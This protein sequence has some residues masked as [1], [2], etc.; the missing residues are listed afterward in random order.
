MSDGFTIDADPAAVVAALTSLGDAAQ[1]YINAAS[2]ETADA[3]VLEAK[4][5]LQRKLGP[6]A[7]GE[8][9]AGI[10]AVPARDGNGYLVLSS[11][12]RIGALPLWLELGTKKGHAGS[13]AS[14]ALAYFYSAQQLQEGSHLRRIQDALQ[15]AIAE[16][17]LGDA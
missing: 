10:E 12:D 11:N 9:V 2:K 3:L 8:T 16:R 15:R 7:T 1:P 4:I 6:Q 5:R 17:G 14:P 13:H